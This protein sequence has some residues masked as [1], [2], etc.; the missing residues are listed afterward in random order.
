MSGM[1]APGGRAAPG[2]DQSQVVESAKGPIVPI[3]RLTRG[4]A[5]V[6]VEGI[7]QRPELNGR[8]G[9]VLGT[10]EAGRFRS[11]SFLA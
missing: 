1:A 3:E 10:E 2:Q 9:F 11:I 4:I 5:R 6:R 8:L 7:V